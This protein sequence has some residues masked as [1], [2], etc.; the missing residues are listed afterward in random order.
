MGAFD[1]H[2]LVG[3]ASVENEVRG[4]TAAYNNL[5]IL[6]VSSGY[7]GKNIGK[8]LLLFSKTQAKLFGADKLYLSATPTQ[9]TVEFYLKNGAELARE[10]DPQ[11]LEQEPEDIHLELK[12]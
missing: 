1:Q 12:V 8:N 3:V 11:L 2:K 7:R 6:Y 10:V 9:H 5:D 4:K